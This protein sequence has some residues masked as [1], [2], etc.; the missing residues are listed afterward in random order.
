MSHNI[1][2]SV[3]FEDENEGDATDSKA[4]GNGGTANNAVEA[5]VI[6]GHAGQEAT[7]AAAYLQLQNTAKFEYI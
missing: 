1:A 3:S 6:N 5:K 4:Y 2:T 7:D